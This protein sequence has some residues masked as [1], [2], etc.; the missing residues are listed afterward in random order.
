MTYFSR[1]GGVMVSV[2][3][4]GPKGRGVKA[5]RGDGLFKSDKNLQHSFLRMWS[6]A[7]GLMS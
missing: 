6:K 5:G 1:L 7:G 3:A 4:T 2:I